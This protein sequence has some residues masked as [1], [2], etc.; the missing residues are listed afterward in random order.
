MA[1][2]QVPLPFYNASGIRPILISIQTPV[3][4]Y[5]IKKKT[6]KGNFRI[7]NGMVTFSTRLSTDASEKRGKE[8][9]NGNKQT[10]KH[11]EKT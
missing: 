11:E 6:K 1:F 8:W 10:N 9:K 7:R 5:F 2:Q 4:T 3:H